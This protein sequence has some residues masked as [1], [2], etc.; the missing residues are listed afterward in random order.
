MGG[1]LAGFCMGIILFALQI[2]KAIW[3]M[4]WLLIG[5]CFTT[6]YFAVT[7]QY[8]YSGKI[9]PSDQLRDVCGYYKQYFDDY[10]CN[11]M[12]EEQEN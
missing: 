5:V 12:R 2:K 6:V 4:F 3:K 7:L 1:L 10:E 8:M 11:C 9:D